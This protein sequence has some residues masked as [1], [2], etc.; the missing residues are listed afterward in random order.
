M[1][2]IAT[3]GANDYINRFCLNMDM[4]EKLLVW[5]QVYDTLFATLAFY[6][7]TMVAQRREELLHASAN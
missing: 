2:H 7:D 5:Q 3:A 6:H 1:N 4:T